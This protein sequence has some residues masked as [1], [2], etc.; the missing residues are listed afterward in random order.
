M[1]GEPLPQDHGFPARVIVPRWAAVASVK[2]VGRVHVSETPLTSPWNTDKYVFT[3]GRFRTERIPVEAQG[4]KSALELPWP[5]R[6]GRGRHTIRGRS[7]SAQGAVSRVEY[8]VDGGPS[9]LIKPN[10]PGAWVRWRF[11]WDARP[12]RH[13]VRARAMD[14]AGNVQPDE[15]PF[16][17]LGYL[18]GAVIGHPV[19][20]T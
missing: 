11:G 4:L 17:E 10:V 16:N 14:T 1:N 18:Y 9:R 15:T 7:W 6:L 2:W 12:G 3:G 8:S 13:E 19:K 5:A 20:V